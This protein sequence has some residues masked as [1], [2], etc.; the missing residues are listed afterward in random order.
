MATCAGALPRVAAG[1][2]LLAAHR[3][4]PRGVPRLFHPVVRAAALLYP[5]EITKPILER[6]QRHL[7]HLRRRTGSR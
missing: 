7:F 6:Y 2:E 3:R 4:E 1:E 5:Q